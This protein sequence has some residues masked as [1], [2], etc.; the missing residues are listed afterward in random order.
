M[1]IVRRNWYLLFPLGE[2]DFEVLLERSTKEEAED[3]RDPRVIARSCALGEKATRGRVLCM[4][5]S[6]GVRVWCLGESP[7]IAKGAGKE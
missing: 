4:H 2:P 7:S 5:C 3:G 6:S 1:T